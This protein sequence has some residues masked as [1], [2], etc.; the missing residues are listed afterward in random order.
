MLG[1][2][3]GLHLLVPNAVKMWLRHVV[4]QCG[5]EVVEKRSRKNAS[6][7]AVTRHGKK[8]TEVSSL[9]RET[10]DHRNNVGQIFAFKKKHG[11]F[12]LLDF[13]APRKR[14]PIGNL[15]SNTLVFFAN[16]AKRK[17]GTTRLPHVVTTW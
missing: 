2:C 8:K 17:S 1:R 5:G 4:S 13:F 7:H 3:S 16:D 6:K 9:M 12:S 15:F 14:S 11:L 10:C